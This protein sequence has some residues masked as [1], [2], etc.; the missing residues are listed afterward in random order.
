MKLFITTSCCEILT[1]DVGPKD[2]V[3]KIKRQINRNHPE[4]PVPC[5]KLVR[6]DIVFNDNAEIENYGVNDGDSSIRLVIKA[7]V[8]IDFT[9]DP[10]LEK[11]YVNKA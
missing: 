6:D 7:I 2:Q 8:P 1:C 11:W 9:I 4:W 3:Q 10:Q 5:M